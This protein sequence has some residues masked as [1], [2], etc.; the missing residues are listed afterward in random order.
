MGERQKILSWNEP[1]TKDT[2]MNIWKYT[3]CQPVR[4]FKYADSGID[5]YD[6]YAD[7]GRVTK[8]ALKEIVADLQ[9][10]LIPNTPWKSLY[11]HVYD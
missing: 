4:E 1:T 8:Q 9:I 6:I 2:D 11:K 10:C 7:T 3:L 5:T